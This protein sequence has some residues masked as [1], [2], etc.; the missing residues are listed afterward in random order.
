MRQPQKDY[1]STEKNLNSTKELKITI[2]TK[3]TWRN[4][5]WARARATE[6]AHPTEGTQALPISNHSPKYPEHRLR[7]IHHQ[8]HL[9]PRIN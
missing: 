8:W 3:D 7:Q 5:G 2:L 1:R 4:L 9:D 6:W